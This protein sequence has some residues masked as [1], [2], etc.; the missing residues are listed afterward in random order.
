MKYIFTLFI[1]SITLFSCQKDQC[2]AEDFIG[3]YAGART[4]V[5]INSE[6]MDTV[7]VTR[8]NDERVQIEIGTYTYE[9]NIDGCELEVIDETILG[10][11]LSG[12]ASHNG[13]SLTVSYSTSALGIV[14]ENCEFIGVLAE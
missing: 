10:N 8:V 6:P 9:A 1:L 11:G 5:G 7:I 2:P 4:C 12:T 13:E 14:I 3:T